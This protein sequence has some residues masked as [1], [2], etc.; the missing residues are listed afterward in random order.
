MFIG[1]PHQ[2]S[3]TRD[4]RIPSPSDPFP[5]DCRRGARRGP[6]PPLFWACHGR[7]PVRRVSALHRLPFH[8]P[9]AQCSPIPGAAATRRLH[10]EPS[11]PPRARRS[12]QTSRGLALVL[13]SPPAVLPWPWTRRSEVFLSTNH[14]PASAEATLG[15][16][17]DHHRRPLGG[18]NLDKAGCS[19]SSGNTTHAQRLTS[20]VRAA[21]WAHR[22]ARAC[23]W[24]WKTRPPAAGWLR[25]G[26]LIGSRF[27]NFRAR[28]FGAVPVVAVGL[29][30]SAWVGGTSAST[31]SHQ[32]H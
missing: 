6:G 25:N 3:L 30:A 10:V 4:C 19:T 15:S 16:R 31:R 27:E 18:K 11:G 12:G 23:C 13:R 20:N 21:R 29:V 28:P 9:A 26:A 2:Q 7:H 32:R 8:G 22:R 17:C 14:V 1:Q 5:P 24:R